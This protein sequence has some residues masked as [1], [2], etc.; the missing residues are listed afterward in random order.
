MA[1]TFVHE[2]VLTSSQVLAPQVKHRFIKGDDSQCGAGERAVGVSV[3][4]AAEVGD[5][6]GICIVGMPL[7]EAGTGGVTKGDRI[8]SDLN[9]CGVTLSTG[10]ENGIAFSSAAEGKLFQIVPR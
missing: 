5:T 6:F 9:G 10:I 4:E 1:S 8:E 3:S 2:T 7:L